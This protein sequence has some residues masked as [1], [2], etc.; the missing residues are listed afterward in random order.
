MKAVGETFGASDSTARGVVPDGTDDRSSERPG[1][2]DHEF[3]L[4]GCAS[5]GRYG[6]RIQA[7]NQYSHAYLVSREDFGVSTPRRGSRGSHGGGA[8]IWRMG[9]AA[10]CCSIWH[11]ACI[12]R[13]R[14]DRQCHHAGQLTYYGSTPCLRKSE[15]HLSFSV[16]LWRINNK[17]PHDNMARTVHV[18]VG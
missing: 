6:A 15:E 18:V 8:Q 14:E 4:S 17:V 9:A 1:F 16:Q 11:S 12:A 5:R 7:P 2:P 10:T 3:N 13:C